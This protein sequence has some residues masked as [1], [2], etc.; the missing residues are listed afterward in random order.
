MLDEIDELNINTPQDV[1]ERN[2]KSPATISAHGEAGGRVIVNNDNSESKQ[3]FIHDNQGF[4][5]P[6]IRQQ[7]TS[8]TT[9]CQ[10][11]TPCLF[12]PDLLSQVSQ[13]IVNFCFQFFIVS[14]CCHY[15]LYYHCYLY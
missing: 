2:T 13:G 1:E 9:T 14:F 5:T 10:V 6:N 3:V 4:K 11:T 15:Y 8:S 12:S 7:K